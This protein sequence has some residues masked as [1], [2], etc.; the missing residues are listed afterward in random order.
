MAH[1]QKSYLECVKSKRKEEKSNMPRL[2]AG[3]AFAKNI[4]V[5]TSAG[6][7][8][9]SKCVFRLNQLFTTHK[10]IKSQIRNA[11]QVCYLVQAGK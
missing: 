2:F 5:K 4:N 6:R 7:S 8:A 9:L 11:L 10:I 1:P 3:T